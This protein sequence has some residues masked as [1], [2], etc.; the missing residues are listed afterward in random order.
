MNFKEFHRRSIE[1]RDSFWAEQAALIEGRDH[2]WMALRE[3]LIAGGAG[4]LAPEPMLAT[5]ASAVSA[6]IPT[7]ARMRLQR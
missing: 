4:P 1:D 5:V 2:D 7:S 6:P 3:D